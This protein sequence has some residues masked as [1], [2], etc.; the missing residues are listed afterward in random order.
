MSSFFGWMTGRVEMLYDLK[1]DPRN[2]CNQSWHCLVSFA[3]WGPKVDVVGFCFLDL[4]SN[5]QP[6]EPLVKW[7]QAGE[8]PI[9]IGFGSL[10]SLFPF[11]S[12]I[13]TF[14][15]FPWNYPPWHSFRVA[16]HIT[17]GLPT[18]IIDLLW[19]LMDKYC[20]RWYLLNNL[21]F[22]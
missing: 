8:K 5:Y 19:Y 3:D 17:E 13:I 2:D 4:A 1:D 16:H 18:L 10:V 21:F 20:F 6:P 15:V 14:V 12:L 22:K 11:H 7:L 9:Y